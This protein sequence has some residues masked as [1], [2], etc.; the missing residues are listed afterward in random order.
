MATATA[1]TPSIP[2][3]YAGDV[4]ATRA[5]DGMTRQGFMLSGTAFVGKF[6]GTVEEFRRAG[7]TLAPKVAR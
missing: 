5:S 6:T 3:D 7:W 1:P 4:T 2:A